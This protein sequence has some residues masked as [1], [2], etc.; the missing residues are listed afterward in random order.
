MGGY[1]IL[2]HT[3]DIGLRVRGESLEELFGE[4][5]R[6]LA[7]IIGVWRPQDGEKRE[8]TLEADDVGA[9]LVDWLSE[10]LYLHDARDALI[11]GVLV[12]RVDEK[13]IAGSVVLVPMKG[14]PD[15]GIQVKAITYHQLKVERSEGGWTAE[16]YLDV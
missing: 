1:E 14:P 13:G 10:I 16:I 12:E 15:E 5:T 4:A 7:E 11:A 9:L 8:I 2:E 3:A 6:G